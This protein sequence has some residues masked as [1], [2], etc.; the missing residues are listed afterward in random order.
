[1]VN[2]Q[3]LTAMDRTTVTITLEQIIQLEETC[4]PAVAMDEAALLLGNL[5]EV[6]RTIMHHLGSTFC[7]YTFPVFQAFPLAF[8]A[9][10]CM[11]VKVVS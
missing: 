10:C 4:R 5:G 6:P 11:H 1:M 8:I 2:K 7:V 9:V 3:Q